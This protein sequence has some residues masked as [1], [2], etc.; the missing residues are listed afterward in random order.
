[1]G[2]RAAVW[3]VVALCGL[4]P[5]C[6]GGG[7]GG[8]TMRPGE[9]CLPCHQ[10][11]DE[12]GFTAAG[13][14]FRQDG[15]AAA[16]LTVTLTDS[17]ATRASAATNSAGNFFFEQPLSPPFDV[18]ITDGAA[19]ASMQGALASCNSCHQ[20]GGAAQAHIVFP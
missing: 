5:G 18:T 12:G 20:A 3:A 2:G 16:G 1:M 14:V 15:T 11:G 6:E 8:A 4:G 10:S 9:D 7:E 13:T 17:A 19:T